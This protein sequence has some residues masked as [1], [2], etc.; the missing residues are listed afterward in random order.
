MCRL[1]GP[2]GT[3][4][5]TGETVWAGFGGMD[6]APPARDSNGPVSMAEREGRVKGGTASGGTASDRKVRVGDNPSR[7]LGPLHRGPGYESRRVFLFCPDL[8]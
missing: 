4:W 5:A 1:C 6:Q 7:Q 2:G 3:L 8:R